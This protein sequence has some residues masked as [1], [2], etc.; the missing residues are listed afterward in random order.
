MPRVQRVLASLTAWQYATGLLALGVG[1]LLLSA[2]LTGSGDASAVETVIQE[3]GALLIVTGALSVMWDVVGRRRFTAEVLEAANLSHD[4]RAARLTQLTD[5]YHAVDWNAHLSRALEVDLFFAYA[6]TW[7]M[8]HD[9]ALRQLMERPGSRTRVVLPN[10][11]NDDLMEQLAVKFQLEHP[12]LLKDRI[13]RAE[14]EFEALRASLHARSMLEVRCTDEFPVYTYY[15]FDGTAVTSLYAQAKGRV[16]TP[17]FVY[18]R[19]GMLF[20]FFAQQFAT[21]WSGASPIP[22][23][24][25]VEA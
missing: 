24:R 12:Q 7:R 17:T 16:D 6:G 22:T 15:R 8:M 25:A 4:V 3:V 21:L 11:G 14:G 1:L 9:G 5:H 20:E 13:A 2:E 18:E 10:A 19:D 23:A